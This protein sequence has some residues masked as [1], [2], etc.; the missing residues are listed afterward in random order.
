[1]NL[2][3]LTFAAT[4]TALSCSP[5]SA[6]TTSPE[7]AAKIEAFYS[8][9]AKFLG[10]EFHNFMTVTMCYTARRNK[11]VQLISADELEAAKQN[12][13]AIQQ[14]LVQQNP[15]LNAEAIWSDISGRFGDLTLT[16]DHTLGSDQSDLQRSLFAGT[17]GAERQISFEN[18]L[19]NMYSGNELIL[20]L[21]CRGALNSLRRDLRRLTNDNAISIPKDF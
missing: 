11:L 3:T 10:F 7:D 20:Q 9:P 17:N 16:L 19:T 8:D 4:V 14:S 15:S 18:R 21:I 1:M 6:Q 13:I 12:I 5:L 2:K